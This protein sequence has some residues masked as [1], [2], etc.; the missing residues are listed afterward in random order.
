MIPVEKNLSENLQLLLV[1]NLGIR[2]YYDFKA[3]LSHS[4]LN[5]S[6]T[7]TDL[8]TVEGESLNA[9]KNYN[10]LVEP[11][12]PSEKCNLKL[13]K[14]PIVQPIESLQDQINQYPI[15]QRIKLGSANVI[16]AQNKRISS[17]VNYKRNLFVILGDDQEQKYSQPSSKSYPNQMYSLTINN[18][19]QARAKNNYNPQKII[20][21]CVSLCNVPTN[22]IINSLA[23]KEDY[24]LLTK[25]LARLLGYELPE[26]I[27]QQKFIGKGKAGTISMDCLSELVR[28]VY[29]PPHTTLL[30]DD[31]ELHYLVK[32][33]PVD[34]LYQIIVTNDE[35]EFLQFCE[36]YGRGETCSML[37]Q[38]ICNSGAK[39]Y[40]TSDTN[41]AYQNEAQKT[42]DKSHYQDAKGYLQPDER[43]FQIIDLSPDLRQKAVEFFT[44]IG[45]SL[46]QFEF[47]DHTRKQG[48]MSLGK[49]IEPQ[50]RKY[51]SK[52]EGLFIYFSRVIRPIWSNYLMNF[53]VFEGYVP[54]QIS[55]YKQEDL[56]IL[57]I[58]LEE[59]REFLQ[60]KGSALL[61]KGNTQDQDQKQF[62]LSG[63]FTTDHKTNFSYTSTSTTNISQINR[64]LLSN[65]ARMN[66][67]LND[68]L[69]EDQVFFHDNFILTI[70]QRKRWKTLANSLRSRFKHWTFTC[71]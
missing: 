14:F 21:E 55:F 38:L 65:Q 2:L 28:Q 19:F 66:E 12:R 39:Y 3:P 54:G 26:H 9:V 4:L 57:K 67:E 33:R 15:H 42:G 36:R 41:R 16:N 6:Q 8:V 37:L 50:K 17:A 60:H 68:I 46:S 70:Y 63:S 13:I 44:S 69:F 5:P 24:N 61:A 23:P 30:L 40:F 18:G 31:C 59:I 10:V 32:F 1:T 49:F 71:V 43:T 51:T 62:R 47:T 7:S 27:Q 48:E 22:V 35:N 64:E 45:N 20:P 25:P 34:I 56:L 11:T 58:R 29:Y 53:Y 52:L